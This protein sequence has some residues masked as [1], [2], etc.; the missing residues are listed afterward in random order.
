M[1][2]S[3][4]KA[5]TPVIAVVLLLMMTVAAAGGAYAWLTQLQNQFQQRTQENI[6]RG[7]DIVSLDCYNDGGTGYVEVFFKN[8]GTKALDLNPIDMNIRLAATSS[9]NYSLTRTGL[10][11]SD[12][13]GLGRG[14]TF[15]E[16]SNDFASPRASAPYKINTFS[17][18]KLGTRYKINFIFTDEDST[19][20][21]GSCQADRRT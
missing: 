11:L 9:I 8:S 3:H 14:I 16:G 7:I 13:G 19:T 12:I 18:F 1:A 6:E 5:I 2:V 20:K 15:I 21:S 10:K 4:R 17:R